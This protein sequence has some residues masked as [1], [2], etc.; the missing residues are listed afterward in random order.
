MN[1]I[2]TKRVFPFQNYSVQDWYKPWQPQLHVHNY[3]Y[4]INFLGKLTG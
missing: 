3:Y 1:A 4:I 2:M